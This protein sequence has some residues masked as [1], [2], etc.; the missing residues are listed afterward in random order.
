MMSDAV[1]RVVPSRAAT[2]QSV[3]L[4][5][6]VILPVMAAVLVA[7]VI[8]DITRAFAAD[9]NAGLLVPV[10]ITI[11]A[12]MLALFSP[13]AGWLAD[14]FGRKRLLVA[15]LLVYAVCGVAP[16]WLDHLPVIIL[17]R[18]LLGICEAAVMTCSTALICDHNQGRERARWLAM[19]SV[20]ASLSSI[21]LIV[22]GGLLGEQNWRTPFAIYGLA[23]LIVPAVLLLVEEAP[24][25]ADSPAGGIAGFPRRRFA[26]I[27]LLALAA[28]LLFYIM[29]IQIGFLL[30]MQGITSPQKIGLAT[31]TGSLAILAGSMIFRRLSRKGT[32]PAAATFACMGVGLLTMVLARDFAGVV[33]GAVLHGFGWGIALPLLLTMA[34]AGLPFDLRGRG[35]GVFMGA[36]FIGQFLS[37]LSVA[38]IDGVLGGL[39]PAIKVFAVLS[40]LLA[41]AAAVSLR[42]TRTDD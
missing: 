32:M 35:T 17:S 34:M 31:A 6:P 10:A 19:Q 27:G 3:S 22:I 38:A 25:E 15:A 41:I 9:P 33:A 5:L 1:V 16:I 18:A 13:L 40:L 37:P 29:P 26:I 11:P 7:P 12:L 4:I 20:M 14:R 21:P 39:V 42:E 8:P 2:A 28:S 36:V 23:V 24:R 30:A